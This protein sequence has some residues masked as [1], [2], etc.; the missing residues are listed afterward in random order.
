MI[1]LLLALSG[2]PLASA[3][4]PLASAGSPLV[5]ARSPLL[6][7][8]ERLRCAPDEAAARAALHALAESQS[9][10]LGLPDERLHRA[11]PPSLR[12]GTLDVLAHTLHQL[13]LHFPALRDDA[14]RLLS[15]WDACALEGAA[16]DLVARGHGLSRSPAATPFPAGG[17]GFRDAAGKDSLLPPERRACW[18][19]PEPQ[20]GPAYPYRWAPSCPDPPPHAEPYAATR[21]PAQPGAA[22]RPSSQQREEL[23][24]LPGATPSTGGI[25][26][27]LTS[28]NHPVGFA[29]Y[30]AWALEGRY[31]AGLSGVWSPLPHFFLRG[32]AGYRGGLDH[33]VF[34]SWGFG[35]DDW[36]PGT[37]SLQIN[38]WGPSVPAQ[39][40]DWRHA[41]VDLGYKPPRLCAQPFCVSTYVALDVPLQDTSFA[42]LR[43]T[44]TFHETWFVRA[45]FDAV[46]D[47]HVRWVY[48]FGRA[49]WRRFAVNL[50]YDNW[51]PNTAFQPNFKQHGIVTLSFNL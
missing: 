27:I 49:D 18:Q 24:P 10:A 5:A 41:I 30:V 50:S 19:L 35:Y 31:L 29:P 34:Y 38:D 7:V 13:A 44:A 22:L 32:G 28:S 16:V 26:P 47:G 36:R 37:F 20:G 39:G 2:S 21:T 40:L 9:G 43:A 12:A 6:D 3:G 25:A 11:A 4:S 42:A 48:G 33:T 45:G 1:A 23:V 51:G 17:Q 15:G 8:A 14:A 46:F